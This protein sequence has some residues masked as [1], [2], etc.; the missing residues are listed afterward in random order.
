[1]PLVRRHRRNMVEALAQAVTVPVVVDQPGRF[2][3]EAEA[4]KP[5][6][7]LLK[8]GFYWGRGDELGRIIR[9]IK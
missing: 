5:G 3:T 2:A 9:S 4:F 6:T 8:R 7:R 1:M